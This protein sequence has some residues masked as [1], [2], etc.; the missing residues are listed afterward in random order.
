MPEDLKN[1][2]NCNT[3]LGKDDSVCPNCG[4]EVHVDHLDD[5]PTRLAGGPLVGGEPGTGE[6]L[7]D[8]E[9]VLGAQREGLGFD[10]SL[11]RESATRSRY[12]ILDT[13]GEGGMGVVYKAEDTKLRRTV[14]IKR[15]LPKAEAQQKGLDR[16]LREAHVVAGLNHI[17]IVNVFDIERD[18]K[19]PFIVMEYVEGKSLERVIEEEGKIEESRA[20]EL[21]KQVCQAIGYAHRVD[22]IHRDIKPANI[23]IT[24]DGVPKVLDFGLAQ[25][26]TESDLSKTG[27]GMGTMYY[28]PPEQTRDAKNVDHRAD[29]Y[30]LGATLYHMLTGERP[31]LIK[32]DKL[33]AGLK[34]LVF[35]C[36]EENPRDRYF[37]I[38]EIL[39][40][41][42]SSVS[43][44]DSKPP[45]L[46]SED[47]CHNCGYVNPESAR[48]CKACGTGLFEKCPKC[49][50]ENRVGS[51]YCMSCGLNIPDFRKAREHTQRAQE[52]LKN[53]KYSRAI[54][55]LK[56]ALQL[57]VGKIEMEALLATAEESLAKLNAHK[58]R[59][60]TL[61]REE[62]YKEAEQEILKALELDPSDDSAEE[63]RREIGALIQEEHLAKAEAL[64][65]EYKF[66]EAAAEYQLVL[67]R[68]SAH[69][70]AIKAHKEV[71]EILD[72]ILNHKK[73]ADA[74][75]E[76]KRYQQAIDEYEQILS[77]AP[78]DAY[79][80]GSV[81]KCQ[82][83]L[84]EIESL[85]R[86]A[87][88]AL[89][90][91]AFPDAIQFLQRLLN[92]SDDVESVT[93]KLELARSAQK[94]IVAHLKEGRRLAD[95]GRYDEAIEEYRKVLSVDREHSK[96]SEE[97]ARIG[98]TVREIEKLEEDLTASLDRGDFAEAVRLIQALQE[99][100][101]DTKW[102]ENLLQE[103]KSKEARI[104]AHYNAA[105]NWYGVRKYCKSIR[106]AER[107]L[108]IAP[109]HAGALEIIEKSRRKISLMLKG[110]AALVILGLS[111]ALVA[112]ISYQIR[113][114][115][116]YVEQAEEAF[117]QEKWVEASSYCMEAL[118]LNSDGKRALQLLAEL[119]PALETIA[120][121]A[122][123]EALSARKTAEDAMAPLYAKTTYESASRSHAEADS[124]FGANGFGPAAQA[125]RGAA[126]QYQNATSEAKTAMAKAKEEA[127]RE[128]SAL[129]ETKNK[130]DAQKAGSYARESFEAG[131]QA[132][133]S[134]SIEYDKQRYAAAAQKYRQAHAY[135]K[136]VLEHVS[137]AMAEE[138]LRKQAAKARV[139][140]E[141]LLDAAKEAEAPKYASS[142]FTSAEQERKKA[143][144]YDRRG[145]SQL[146][147]TYYE[148]AQSL[149][150]NSVRTARQEKA[151]LE[152]TAK[153]A[154]RMEGLV[155]FLVWLV[156][157]LFC[158]FIARALSRLSFRGGC[159][160]L[161]FIFL[162]V[163]PILQIV[164]DEYFD[165]V[166]K[167]KMMAPI[168]ILF[169][170]VATIFLILK[171]PRHL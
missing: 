83:L 159:G 96:A 20:I 101:R 98:Q 110:F 103:A 54:K 8:A 105:T 87:N 136:N 39:V 151:R 59:A 92:L 76:Q 14:A 167:V 70:R 30:A 130:I 116:K 107:I 155:N 140:M 25:M 5:Q 7:D 117:K 45:R 160:F 164:M 61:K 91:K 35:K 126:E 3:Q 165:S 115:S 99:H 60:Q 146:A 55:E 12:R 142:E 57:E 1:C 37:S 131:K 152:A 73:R 33:S 47:A 41:V 119:A 78:T 11:T 71:R 114:Y 120:Q 102:A 86:K 75:L 82:K 31:K 2:L 19:G 36:M 81:K 63:L 26:A 112:Y 46:E 138:E 72:S 51:K 49:E 24:S 118:E 122:R 123:E 149:Y 141:G 80:K 62:K 111:I 58:E 28:M 143:E 127:D 53:Y 145:N 79:A 148:K 150:E 104:R 21:F 135:Y 157:I 162:V 13:L 65:R 166:T 48:F 52:Y 34:A 161:I 169:T 29:I 56:A 171:A 100:K 66:E 16:F 163:L 128:K 124:H 93:H 153:K 134:A 132:E 44:K 90:D 147:K 129:G 77:L 144:E 32:A 68:N 106:E 139:A 4:L 9:T 40:D 42:E 113:N 137:R 27:Y 18:A 133:R 121:D 64:R 74:L 22:I 156:L 15:L 38:S 170:I 125:Y 50:G 158:F 89:A 84:E 109:S 168:T 85:N 23:I 97:L 95:N 17:N 94:Q 108:E 88:E 6:L 67:E 154:E 69:E 10:S 43:A